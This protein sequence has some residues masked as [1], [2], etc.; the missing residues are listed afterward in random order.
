MVDFTAGISELRFKRCAVPAGFVDG[1]AQL[2]IF[3]DASQSGYGACAYLRITSP[4][5]A[6]A[7]SL[8]ESKGRL[9]PLKSVTIP[10]LEF[11]GAVVSVRL[12]RRIRRALDVPLLPS[13]FWSDSQIPL[14]YIRNVTRRFKVFVANRV[15][16]IRESTS[17]DQW[18]H[19]SGKENPADILSRGRCVSDLSKM[20][21]DG[22]AF[23]SCYKSTWLVT[24]APAAD[25]P[26]HDP[27]VQQAAHSASACVHK[28]HPIDVLAA[29]YSSFYKL[30][31]AISWLLRVR[32]RLT[33]GVIMDGEVTVPE[34]RCAERMIISHV[35]STEYADEIK[36]L[37][38]SGFVSQSSHMR[39]L[40]PIL[41]GGLIVVGGRLRH[42]PVSA[43]SRF[44]PILPGDHRVSNLI[45][46]D[47]HGGAHLGTEWT[48]S[49]LRS[50]FWITH[51]RNLIK[52]VKRQCVTC[53]RLYTAPMS[54]R[55]ADLPPERCCPGAPH[56]LM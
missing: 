2:H 53:K 29:H 30:K 8:L 50:Q 21:F 32:S 16:E 54:Q 36:Q 12:E 37:S 10:R 25:V 19:I 45:V 34:M 44:Q 17:A 18:N 6:I 43:V 40:S 48:L 27:E 52:R 23:L 22:P 28:P 51:A 31:K 39:K 55:M 33:S 46:S 49:R 24:Q 20:W 9:A 41:Q 14:A 4:S 56:S 42:A 35:Q 11:L 1:V 26:D 38:E 47:L 7:V 15:S 3:C 5:G 13:M